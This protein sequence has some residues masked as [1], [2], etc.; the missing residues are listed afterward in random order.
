MDI[1][2]IEKPCT[3]TQSIVYLLD[4]LEVGFMRKYTTAK[5]YRVYL[6]FKAGTLTGCL[7]AKASEYLLSVINDNYTTAAQYTKAIIDKMAELRIGKNKHK[8][9]AN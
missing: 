7:S 3:K 4:V 6:K 9:L 2:S 8:T 1:S 5:E